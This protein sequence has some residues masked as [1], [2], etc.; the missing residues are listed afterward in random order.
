MSQSAHPTAELHDLADGR[1][2]DQAR[3]RVEQHVRDCAECQRDWEAITAI[4]RAVARLPQVAVPLGFDTKLAA[5]L[6]AVANAQPAATSGVETSQSGRSATRASAQWR[7]PWTRWAA[8]IGIAATIIVV[9]MLAWWPRSTNLPSRA[10]ADVADYTAGRLEMANVERDAS[11][12]NR[13]FAERV[14]FPVRVFDLGMMGYT[15]VGGRVHTIG[16]HESAL[17]VYRGSGGS[18][19]C[20]MYS[21]S[22]TELPA[23]AETR[24][25]NGFTFLVY[26]EAG[27]TQVFSR[28]GGGKHTHHGAFLPEDLRSTRLVVD[29]EGEAISCSRFRSGWKFR[30]AACVHLTDER[31]A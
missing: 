8:P 18:L 21:G 6:D 9:A 24:T 2:D 27:G 12:L 25:A 22:A 31:P 14:S 3:P 1:L 26:H 17:W 20:Q 11:A 28:Q 10:A 23:P 19:I 13:Y 15:L 29:E 4:K 30:R 5:A 7:S 16:S